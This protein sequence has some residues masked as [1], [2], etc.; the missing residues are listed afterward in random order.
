MGKRAGFDAFE[1][2]PAVLLD[3]LD[4]AVI[5]IAPEGTVASWNS[6][7]ASLFG[8]SVDDVIGARFDELGLLQPD[9]PAEP[10]P[11][12]PAGRRC[13][14]VRSDGSTF[15]A[16]VNDVS[17]GA[18]SPAT[19]G[20]F[21][22]VTDLS[23]SVAAAR[24]V[25]RQETRWWAL[26]ARSAD[27]AVVAEPQ[28]HRVIYA[29]PAASRLFGWR[30]E[31]LLGELG[32]SFVHP[33]DADRVAEAVGL[34]RDDPALHPSV[35]FRLR[36]ADGS[37]RWVEETLTNLIDE[38]SVHGVVA[39]IRDI[40]DRRQAEDALRASEARYR[41]IMETA[42]EG[43]WA[44][45]LAGRTM[46]AN[47]KVA[48]LLGYS[49]D[50]VYAMRD[51]EVADEHAR[52]E[53]GRR[54][55]S[56]QAQGADCYE[57]PYVRPD[58][59]AVVLRISASPLYED[60]RHIGSFAMVADVTAEREAERELRQRATTDAL[61]GLVN[62]PYLLEK[63]QQEL[64]GAAQPRGRSLAVLVADIDQFK[65]VNDTLGH[66]A[67]D[68]LL[69][70]VSRRWEAALRPADVLARFGGDE[71]VVLCA[72]AQEPQARRIAARLQRALSRPIALRGRSISINASVGIAV[73][74]AG[75]VTGAAPGEPTPDADTLLGYADAAMYGAKSD[76]PGQA[77]VFT[78]ALITR[79]RS[80]LRLIN[81]LRVALESEQLELH[82]QPVVDLSTGRLLGV[83]AL[84]RWPHP[85][86]GL[87]PPGEFIIAA[88]ESG[89]IEA[90][91]NWVIRRACIDGAA[92][93]GDG[94]LPPAAYV[95]VN[96]FAG[97]LGQPDF[98]T[99]LCI[100]LAETGMSAHALVL[101]VTESAVMRDPDAALR[102]LERLQRLGIRVAVD[103]FGTGYSSLGRLSQLPVATLKI[104]RGFVRQITDRADKR[105]IV[106]AVIDLGRALDVTS[107]AEGI[108]TFADLRLLKDLGCHA[109]QGFL[110]SPAL[111]VPALAALLADLPHG[112]FA[113][114]PDA[115]TPLAAPV[116]VPLQRVSP[117][118]L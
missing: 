29:S 35:E 79:S 114:A 118:A 24:E 55:H 41:L 50:E 92:M 15:P 67:G 38:P 117:P 53:L 78:S 26:V 63:L 28:E 31:Q 4:Q 102:V 110:W 107:T 3:A 47:E 64:D 9:A 43:I 82:Y 84:C 105:A 18:E 103:D 5:G 113:L 54:A 66:A 86:R 42:Q 87:V 75:R 98:E 106:T 108:E 94:I 1:R 30:P 109:G 95:A 23:E 49:L 20:V 90:L 60:G 83:E 13:L 101:E 48:Q 37:Y 17:V 7:A 51:F 27:L 25:E 69:I 81:D 116:P 22:V 16:L 32:R 76:G 80:R 112:R 52:A 65:L 12:S 8:R 33:D 96:V 72:D 70:E 104:D 2:L 77:R 57:I 14:G 97:H 56:R 71:F 19:S 88:E 73:V 68:E 61:T 39:N 6:A 91:D 40:H 85:E 36:C 99:E 21:R 111:P 45:D 62:R 59:T 93:R 46:Y 115:E 100:A 34:V 58:G 11:G 10:R 89:L 44:G 74:V